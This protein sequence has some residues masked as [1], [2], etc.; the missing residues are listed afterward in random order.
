MP[1]AAEVP[2]EGRHV[3][4]DELGFSEIDSRARLSKAL[5][6]KLALVEGKGRVGR[7]PADISDDQARIRP[8]KELCDR[9]GSLNDSLQVIDGPPAVRLVIRR[10]V[11]QL[12]VLEELR[13]VHHQPRAVCL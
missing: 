12:A 3:L 11:Q 1:L 5:V 9:L 8:G 7:K 6:E 13:R 10:E 2:G 4:R